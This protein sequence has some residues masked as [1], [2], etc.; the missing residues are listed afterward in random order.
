MDDDKLMINNNNLQ[1]KALILM[2][3]CKKNKVKI[4][5]IESC[6]AGMISAAITQI[7][8]SSAIFDRGFVTYSNVSKVNTVNVKYDLIDKFGAVSP[9]VALAMARG[10]L[11]R[12]DAAVSIAITGIA[13]P[14][15]GTKIKPVGLVYFAL[16]SGVNKKIIQK[17][18]MFLGDRDDIRHQ[19]T[20]T[21][22][23]LLISIFN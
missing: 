13:G 19:S 16:I 8:G 20:L 23:D 10:G 9:E 7:P 18:Y 2:E 17:K 21:G 1:G 12:S 15:G 4:V 6:T 14:D 11:E 22:I 5:T 3:L